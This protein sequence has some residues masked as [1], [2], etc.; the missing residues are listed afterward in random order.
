MNWL[1]TWM[2]VSINLIACP[3]P[4]PTIDPYR[5]EIQQ[6]T[7]TLEACYDREERL[8]KRYFETYEDAI[9]FVNNGINEC[10]QTNLSN[11][12]M[13]CD[14]KNFQIREIE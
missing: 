6:M 2:V 13:D 14:L 5:G 8:M 11:L 1:V 10:K 7:T 3:D 4:P 9:E 12:F